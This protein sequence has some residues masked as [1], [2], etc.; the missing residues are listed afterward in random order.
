VTGLTTGSV[1]L[2]NGATFFTVSGNGSYSFPGLIA[3]QTAYS[4]LVRTEPNGQACSVAN[5]SGV[6]AGANVTNVAVSCSPAFTITGTVTYDRVPALNLS[7]GGIKLGYPQLVAKPARRVVVLAMQAGVAVAQA[8]TNDQGAFS[9]NVPDGS[10]VTLRAVAQ[11]VATDYAPDGI[12]P[13]YCNGAS[14]NISVVDNTHSQA[15]YVLDGTTTYTVAATGAGLHAPLV[16]SGGAYQNR[17]AAPF[18]ILDDVVSDLETV[19]QGGPAVTLPQM[20]LNWSPSNTTSTGSVSL[21]QIGS[22]HYSFGVPPN[23]YLLGM[24]DVDTDEYDSHVVAHEFGHFIEHA[25]Y[26]ADTLGGS[27]AIGDVLE[28]TTAFSEGYATG[29][30]AMALGDPIYVDTQGVGQVGGFEIPTDVAPS[31]DQQG[32]FDEEAIGWFMW[33]LYSNRSAEPGATVGFDRIHNILANYQRTTLALTSLVSFASFYNQVYG[34]SSESLETLWSSATGLNLPYNALCLGSCSGSGDVA[35]PF[36]S[37]N[38]IGNAFAAGGSSPRHYPEGSTST[39]PAAFW[40]SYRT[41]ADGVNSATAH[42]QTQWGGYSTPTNKLGDVRAYRYVASTTGMT[43]IAVSASG[44]SCS[45]VTLEMAIVHIGGT[46]AQVGMTGCPSAQFKTVAGRTYE[47]Y[48][49]GL[50]APTSSWTVTVTP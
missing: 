6:T 19:C 12:A 22:S 10:S 21:G 40:A 47:M 48:L 41:L 45:S 32:N 5:A 16:F 25:I 39:Y 49:I 50:T 23:I 24:E 30:S 3:N 28:P 35:D 20:Y 2:Q 29:L 43:T 14:W 13:D 38:D 37:D 15:Q 33:S 9:I 27:H 7:N 31:G 11:L 36:D 18:A 42:E 26:R 8:S 1:V 46:L 34:G 44:A 17:A 4:V